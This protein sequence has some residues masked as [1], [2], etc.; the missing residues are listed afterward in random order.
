MTRTSGTF[1]DC[2]ESGLPQEGA[3]LSKAPSHKGTRLAAF[4]NADYARTAIV[5]GAGY[6]GVTLAA[7]LGWLQALDQS[8]SPPLYYGS[9]CWALN[10]GQAMSV[11][12][13]GQLSLLYA[14]LLAVFFFF[15]GKPRAGI[16]I[17]ASLLFGVGVEI[18]SKLA[19]FHPTPESILS[20][21]QDCSD[22]TLALL[23]VSMP[24]SLPSGF[25]IRAAYFGVLLAGLLGAIWPRLRTPTRW[26]MLLL[27]TVL[28]ASRIMIAWHWMSDV[29]A[30]LLLGGAAAY[31]V[32]AF[33]DGFRWLGPSAVD[34]RTDA[35]SK[36]PT[37][38]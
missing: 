8:L 37:R 11:L 29:L 9:P 24:N 19:V 10:A 38:Q 30:G 26:T 2:S 3:S 18:V 20:P 22:T 27:I 5:L 36:T 14:G 4:M 33:A 6:I 7:G 31:G 28:G 35:A 12:L 32:L 21:R 13:E 17:V 1:R 25:S 23:R 34:R 16:F 15:H